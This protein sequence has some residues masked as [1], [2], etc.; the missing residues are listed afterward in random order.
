MD[1]KK[2][3]EL[4]RL[5]ITEDEAVTYEQQFGKILDYF[6]QLSAISTEGVEPLVTPIEIIH[7]YRVDEVVEWQGQEDALAAAPEKQG[8]LFRVPPVV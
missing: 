8:K 1:V 5:A 7:D 3:A 4:A 2:V 6:E